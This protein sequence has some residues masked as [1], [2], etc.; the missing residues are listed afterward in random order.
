M[1]EGFIQKDGQGILFTNKF[2]KT[3]AHPDFVGNVTLDGT[4]Y[5][6]AAWKKSCDKGSFLSLRVAVKEDRE[7][8]KPAAKK[9]AA[10]KQ[11]DDFNF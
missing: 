2:K 6:I 5:E 4:Q 8:T 1:S 10:K 9:P 3:E 11:D 7:S